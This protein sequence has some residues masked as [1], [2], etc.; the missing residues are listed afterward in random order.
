MELI[1]A[2]FIGLWMMFFSFVSYKYMKKEFEC[3]KMRREGK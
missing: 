3:E 1:I 2:I